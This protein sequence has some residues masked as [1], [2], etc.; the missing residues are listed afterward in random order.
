MQKKQIWAQFIL[1]TPDIGGKY[2]TEELL[3]LGPFGSSVYTLVP[4]KN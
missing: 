4:F 1:N 2:E 3:E